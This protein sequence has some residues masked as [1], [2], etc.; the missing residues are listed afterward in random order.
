MCEHPNDDFKTDPVNDLPD[1][2]E[3]SKNA[4]N[5]LNSPTGAALEEWLI[6]YRKWLAKGSS[7]RDYD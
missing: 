5:E 7:G 3:R 1:L 6:E 4:A 2:L